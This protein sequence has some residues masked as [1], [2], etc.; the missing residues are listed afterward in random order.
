MP[1]FTLPGGNSGST[2]GFDLQSSTDFSGEGDNEQSNALR[3]SVTVTVIEV[4]ANGYLRVRGEKRIGTNGGNEYVKLSGI[5]RPEDVDTNNTVAS[6]KVADATLVYVGD[7]QVADA[8]V[9][10]WLARFFISALVP[11]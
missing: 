9:M 8:N 7:G 5:V 3:G 1:S 4:L 11:F 6:T 10:G 2:L